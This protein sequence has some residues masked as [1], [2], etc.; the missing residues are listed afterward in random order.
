[1][2]KQMMNELK[3][4]SQTEK[5]NLAKQ[6]LTDLGFFTAYLWHIEDVQTIFECD[7]DSAMDVLKKALENDATMEQI[8]LAIRISGDSLGLEEKTIIN[9]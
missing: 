7:D 8:W 3:K 9:P 2:N 1:M 6:M 4:L 5:T